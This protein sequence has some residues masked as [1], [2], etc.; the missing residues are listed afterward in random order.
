MAKEIAEGANITQQ[1]P[2]S[3]QRV[4]ESP[5]RPFPSSLPIELTKG[6]LRSSVRFPE[7]E[8]FMQ[9]GNFLVPRAVN[10]RHPVFLY[11][12][13]SPAAQE[14]APTQPGVITSFAPIV[15]KVAPS[16]VTVFTTQTVSRGVTAFPFSDDAL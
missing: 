13:L 8:T 4:A 6:R 16:V 11:E 3:C 1:K 7:G 14:S 10:R 5:L 12:R 15:E 9:K 2:Q